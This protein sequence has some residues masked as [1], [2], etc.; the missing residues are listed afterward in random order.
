MQILAID[1]GTKRL[2]LAWSD[3]TLGVVLPYGLIEKDT[4]PQKVQAVVALLEKE[5]IDLVVVGFPASL[6]GRENKNTERVKKFVFELQKSVSAPI[7]YFDERF[8]SGQADAMGEGVSR[9]EKAAMVI[10]E[11]YLERKKLPS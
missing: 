4:L 8:S 1:F 11:G 2:G 5:K 3:A 9:D 7:E 10:L 6:D